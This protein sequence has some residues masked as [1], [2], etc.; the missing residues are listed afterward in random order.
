MKFLVDAQLPRQLAVGLNWRGHDTLHT[1]D[2]PLGN[3]TSDTEIN[4]ISVEEQRVVVSKD[5]DF[6]NSFLLFGK[7]FKLLLISVGNI[8][9]RALL[10]LFDK[11]LPMMVAA[12]E[13]YDF[14]ELT[15]SQLIQHR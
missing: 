1:L 9:N 8:S 15:A 10:E 4:R 11:N 3:R 14:I 2:L 13:S 12:L 7:P 6:V 5:A